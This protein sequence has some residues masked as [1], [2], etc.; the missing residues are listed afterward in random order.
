MKISYLMFRINVK[1]SDNPWRAGEKIKINVVLYLHS[2]KFPWI[3]TMQC[4]N[5]NM[6]SLQ[7]HQ[8]NDI[9][10]LCLDLAVT[11]SLY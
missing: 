9:V 8:E 6:A 2:C 3:V 1:A 10:F 11:C 5:H 7:I 4:H